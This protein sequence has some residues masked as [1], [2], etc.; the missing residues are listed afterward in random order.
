MLLIDDDSVDQL[1]YG[2]V[3]NQSELVDNVYSFFYAE[4]ALEFM[5]ENRGEGI[6]VILL[7]IN[8]PRMS[9]FDFLEAASTEFGDMFAHIVVVMLTTSL[10]PSDVERAKS[11]Q[12]VKAFMNKPLTGEDLQNI[13]KLL[14]DAHGQAQG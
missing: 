12:V 10:D 13:A 3:V 2:R 7:D 4:E 6:D 14:R 5:R 11:F 8:M 1:L 9:G